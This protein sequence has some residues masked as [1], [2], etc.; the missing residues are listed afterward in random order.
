MFPR[1]T[2]HRHLLRSGIVGAGTLAVLTLVTAAALTPADAKTAQYGI[3]T[4]LSRT[5]S[6]PSPTPTSSGAPTTSNPTTASPTPTTTSPTTASP[7][8][9][10]LNTAPSNGSCG[11]TVLYK[12]DG[13]PWQCSFDDEFAGKTLDSSKW[14]VWNGVNWATNGPECY[15]SDPKY[16]NVAGGVLN[17]NF[18]K[19]PAPVTCGGV[20]NTSTYGSGFVHSKDKFSQAYGRWEIRAKMASGYGLDSALWLW[21]QNQL[22][23][24]HAEVDIAEDFGWSPDAPVSSLHWTDPTNTIATSYN[25]C[26]ISGGTTSFHTY[27]MEWTSTAITFSY[28]GV[29]CYRATAWT[30]MAGY[31]LPAPFNQPFYTNLELASAP[32]TP[33]FNSANMQIDYV[34][35]WK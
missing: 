6:T 25:Q 5:K 32:V 7:T 12:S 14:T 30:P 19:L 27:S 8:S 9:S 28:D 26:A 11:G 24:G 18:V 34:R 31:T 1:T 22:Y 29:Q 16:V 21:P 20:G 4:A 23:P 15:Y 35:I 10:S 3:G 13:T 2:S 17:I 33:N